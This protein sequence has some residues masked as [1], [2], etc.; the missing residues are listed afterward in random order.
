[1][2]TRAILFLLILLLPSCAI[3]DSFVDSYLE[4]VEADKLA[5]AR[6]TI[7]ELGGDPAAYPLIFNSLAPAADR[8]RQA[9]KL[10]TDTLTA[11]G[12][13]AKVFQL[14]IPLFAALAVSNYRGDE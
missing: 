8:I 12:D 14:A 6:E 7:T 3:A 2:L 13:F 11:T 9:G 10:L 1:V 5:L 4:H